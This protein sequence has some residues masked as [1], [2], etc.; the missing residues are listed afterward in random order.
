MAVK[1]KSTITLVRVNDGATGKGVSKTEVFYYRSTSNTTQTGGSWVTT[2][3]DWVD[4]TYFWQKIK[5]TFTDG[6]ASESKPVCITGGKGNAGATGSAGTSVSS[7]TTEFY[8]S[9]SKTTQTGGSWGTTMPTWSPGK[10]LWTRSKIVYVNPSSTKY[11][12]PICDSSWEAVNEVSVGGRNLLLQSDDEATNNSYPTQIYTMSEKMVTDQTYTC[13]LWGSLGEG[14][15]AY[16]LYLDGGSIQLGIMNNNGDGTFSL[17]FKGK[18]GSL[19]TSKLYVCPTPNSVTTDSSITKIKLEKG[20]KATDWSPAPEDMAT[21]EDIDN[22]TDS[23]TDAIDK[24]S[25]AMIDIDAL[26]ESISHL[27]TDSNGGSL[28]TQGPD[29]WTFNIGDIT[30]ALDDAS[31]KLQ[32]L[33]GSVDGIDDTVNKLDSLVNDLGKKTAYITMS[34]DENGAPCIE[35]GKQG[36]EFKVRITNTSIDFIQGSSKIAYINNQSL[37]IQKAIVKDEMQIGEGSG[38]IWK[39][40]GNGNMGLRWV[41]DI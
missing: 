30:S 40:R 18:A 5:T 37:Y 19:D 41:G 15:T 1:V 13:T 2:P 26:N 14:K 32:E 29:G 35:L 28:M 17:T 10:Y 24:A 25:Q 12:A 9:A 8:L 16:T 33:T 6:T 21:S 34:T 36:N 4:G 3:P 22:I 27:V 7:I 38:F 20:N 39:R 11:T 31:D 23:V